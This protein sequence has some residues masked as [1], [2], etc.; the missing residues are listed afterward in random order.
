V[1]RQQHHHVSNGTASLPTSLA[2]AAT[3]AAVLTTLA[4]ASPVVA[5]AGAGRQPPD[6][7]GPE[8][9]CQRLERQ[10]EDSRST[11]ASMTL[12][13][14]CQLAA[15]E[16]RLAAGLASYRTR[17]RPGQR[18][19]L[20]KAQAA[21]LRARDAWCTFASSG[22]EGGSARPMVTLQCQTEV[23][24]ARVEELAR[25]ATCEAG[26]LGCPAW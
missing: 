20:D 17:L 9:A 12:T 26:D 21:W 25:I 2:R 22:A 23:T 18:E 16:R 4:T 13:A 8:A 1:Y 7:E 24:R 3:L 15:A 10:G 5:Q 19:L 6:P 14:R 11:Q